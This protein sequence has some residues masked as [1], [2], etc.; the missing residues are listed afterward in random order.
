M[1]INTSIS[2][3]VYSMD[4]KHDLKMWDDHPTQAEEA[5]GK[6]CLCGKFLGNKATCSGMLPVRLG[7]SNLSNPSR[8]RI[9]NDM[10][11]P[12]AAR[13]RMMH[14]HRITRARYL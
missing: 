2:E 14:P 3:T 7:A 1:K 10:M 13:Q 6:K 11:N 12:V 9:P 5:A 4:R 8:V